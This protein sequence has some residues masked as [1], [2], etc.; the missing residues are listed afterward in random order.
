MT[1]LIPHIIR[2]SNTNTL[3]VQDDDG[4]TTFNV[5]TI[6]NQSI[7][8]NG[9]V[10][11]PSIRFQNSATSGIY[12]IG[13]NN[14]GFSTNGAKRVDIDNTRTQVTNRFDIENTSPVMR[15]VNTDDTQTFDIRGGATALVIS[16]TGVQNLLQIRADDP[17]IRVQDGTVTRPAYS[18]IGDTNSGMY[19]I[20]NNFI[21]ISTNGVR[22]MSIGTASISIQ[23]TLE[24]DDQGSSAQIRLRRDDNNV[25]V[26]INVTD[27]SGITGFGGSR[28]FLLNNLSGESRIHLTTNGSQGTTIRSSGSTNQTRL[29]IVGSNGSNFSEACRIETSE[30]GSTSSGQILVRSNGSAST[31]TVSFINDTNTG[32]YR[33]TTNQIGFATNGVQRVNI[34]NLEMRLELLLRS[35]IGTE[36]A[37]T[38]SFIG[39]T[40]SGMYRPAFNIIGFSTGGEER[41]RIT[42]DLIQIRPVVTLQKIS[43][44]ADDNKDEREQTMIEAFLP[45]TSGI[46]NSCRGYINV[47]DSW[48]ESTG[49]RAVM[50]FYCSSNPSGSQPNANVHLLALETNWDGSQASNHGR[51]RIPD[52]N[53]P[54]GLKIDNTTASSSTSTGAL[55]VSGGIG[56][57]SNVNIDGYIG[58]E[59]ITTPSPTDDKL[60]NIDGDIFWD[61]TQLN[62]TTTADTYSPSIFNGSNIG[63]NVINF[64]SYQQ[65][66]NIVNINIGGR[67]GQ[68]A[69]T[70][71]CEFQITLPV[72]RT[73]GNFTSANQGSGIISI[74]DEGFLG[75]NGI[76]SSVNTLQRLNIIWQAQD[77][78]ASDYCITGSYT[79]VN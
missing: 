59:Q 25:G 45:F 26:N 9:T 24:I 1:S 61:G 34:G 8:N 22:R 50:D 13:A 2:N 37:P 49:S 39:N 30:S 36:S 10:S 14:L 15:F 77:S 72:A 58:L 44:P 73:S 48:L 78:S 6:N 76:V 53:G 65:I 11:A 64:A 7:F 62:T 19:R 33:I 42:N 41:L 69:D 60:Y 54:Q 68:T 4:V 74:Y 5:D 55:V 51:V 20:S 3:D 23:P 67:V 38:Y 63:S 43:G 52:N 16:D 79:L 56:V 17:S 71:V 35:E 47:R 46:K 12:A 75:N 21:G 18:F 57:G 29:S 31:P 40:G 28:D 66:G 70:Q 27:L 32:M